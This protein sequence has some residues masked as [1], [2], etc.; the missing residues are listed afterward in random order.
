MSNLL[1][2]LFF[3]YGADK[4]PRIKHH[5]SDVYWDLFK[6]KRETVKKVLEIGVAEGASLFAWRDFFPNATIYG[7]EIDQER[8]DKL[9]GLPHI[10][11]YQ[12]DQ[13]SF[14]DIEKLQSFIQADIDL[15][16][17]DGSHKPEDQLFT[18]DNLMWFL[19]K[20]AIYIIED[21]DNSSADYLFEELLD[22]DYNVQ[23]IR[24]GKRHD[25]RLIIVRHR[26]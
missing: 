15:V 9:R 7:A 20:S 12:V 21:V 13:T 23:M 1:D 19:K 10:Q 18:C 22:K 6:D 26:Q 24:V 3:K 5:Y 8:V 14:D 11:V 4:T 25:D 2:D 16:I 17:D